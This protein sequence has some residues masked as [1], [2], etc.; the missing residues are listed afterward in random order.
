MVVALQLAAEIISGQ[1]EKEQGAGEVG[2]QVS[3]HVIQHAGRLTCSLKRN[4][5]IA[6]AN[7]ERKMKRM[8]M[9]N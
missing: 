4:A 5:K 1:L 8:N 2:R 6:A 9:K 3:H 7:S